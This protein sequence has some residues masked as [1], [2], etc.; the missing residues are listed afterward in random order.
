MKLQI[1]SSSEELNQGIEWAQQLAL[2]YAHSSDPVGL[3]Y[4]AALPGRE[5]FCMRDVAHQSIG[6]SIL[7]LSQHNKNMLYKFAKNISEGKD[8]C[9]Y[10]EINCNNLPVKEDYEADDKFWYNLPANFDVLDCCLRQYLWTGDKD[11]LTDPVFLNFY[12]RTVRDYVKHWDKDGDGLIEH[13]ISYGVRGIGSYVEDGLHVSM[14]G[15]LVA[16]QYAGYRAYAHIQGLIGNLQEQE[17]FEKKAHEIQAIYTQTWWDETNQRFHGAKLTDG[18]FYEKYYYSGHFLPLYYDIVEDNHKKEAALQEVV[19]ND[20]SNV[21]ELSYLPQVYFKC[22][23]WDLAYETTLRLMNPALE[24]REYP[25]VSYSAVNSIV[26][27]LMGISADAGKRLITITPRFVESLEWIEASQIPVL[28]NL[29]S[30]HIGPQKAIT[31]VNNLGLSF[32]LKLPDR[33]VCEV[34]AGERVVRTINL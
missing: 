19:I 11:Y 32:F 4:E 2:S 25:E 17:E 27:G 1:R 16:A 29:I 28:G 15:D 9:T 22:G 12:E 24:R 8:W 6:A 30:I 10:W 20:A 18:S 33:A 34:R 3:W 14:A 26:T 31:V 13:Y 5:A 21:E 7:G 23:L